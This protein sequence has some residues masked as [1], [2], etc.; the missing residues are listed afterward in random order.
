MQLSEWSG[1]SWLMDARHYSTVE[2]VAGGLRSTAHLGVGWL[3]WREC[4]SGR[5]LRPRELLGQGLLGDASLHGI[6][7]RREYRKI[8][9]EIHGKR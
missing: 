2:L 9:N 1:A 3:F 5:A 6:N 8:E 7:N 4:F